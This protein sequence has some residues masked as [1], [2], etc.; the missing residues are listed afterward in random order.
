MAE[1]FAMDLS[2]S[3]FRIAVV[4]AGTLHLVMLRDERGF[5]CD[6]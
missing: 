1:P 4:F 6:I 2:P 5:I 3:W